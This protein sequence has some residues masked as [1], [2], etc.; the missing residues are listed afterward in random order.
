M[1]I[2]DKP[3]L[4]TFHIEDV[5]HILPQ[6]AYFDIINNKAVLIDVREPNELQF[7]RIT[8][9][10]VLSHPMSV[11]VERLPYISKNQN[12]ILFCP[13]GIR[14]TKV[15]NLL[16]YQGYPNVANLDGGLDAWKQAGLPFE[17]SFELT[18][19]NDSGCGCGCNITDGVANSSCC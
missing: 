17:R 7:E 4:Q 10:N 2:S 15:A 5:K 6:D 1:N 19:K 11:I 3:Q 8:L 14:S 12:I 13:G 9:P 18:I 16:N